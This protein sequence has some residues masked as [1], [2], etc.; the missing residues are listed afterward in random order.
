MKDKFKIKVG[1]T[2]RN[3]NLW[4]KKIVSEKDGIFI[5]HE[6]NEYNENGFM[7]GFESDKGYA[8]HLER[9]EYL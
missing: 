8:K 7:I 2:H 9:T 5:D 3:Y 4:S 1:E 6:G